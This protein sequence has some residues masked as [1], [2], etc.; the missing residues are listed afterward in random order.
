MQPN[1]P[2]SL[3]QASENCL[4]ASSVA[5]FG[6]VLRKSKYQGN[7]TFQD[8]MKQAQRAKGK[9]EDGHRSEFIRLVALTEK[10]W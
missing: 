2:K 10:M 3:E 1:E 9:D 5:A 8:V 6:M 4:F 7:S